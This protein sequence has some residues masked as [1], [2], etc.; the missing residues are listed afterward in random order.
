MSPPK[1]W[2]GEQEYCRLPLFIVTTM[3]TAHLVRT[4]DLLAN[5]SYFIIGGGLRENSNSVGPTV[6]SQSST[7]PVKLIVD[8]IPS[9]STTAVSSILNGM[10][11]Q[12]IS[13]ESLT[14]PEDGEEMMIGTRQN[15]VTRKRQPPGGRKEPKVNTNI[16]AK[17]KSGARDDY[18]K[19]KS[20]ASRDLPSGICRRKDNGR[21]VSVSN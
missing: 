3:P 14:K 8:S 15:D 7:V 16:M 20:N 10:S 1:K 4:D 13:I 19:V 11:S 2:L 18:N 5:G 17:V 6:E 12:S 9:Y 21:Y